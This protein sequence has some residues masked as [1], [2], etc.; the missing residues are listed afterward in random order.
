[1]ML[2]HRSRG[3]QAC[4]VGA[5]RQQALASAISVFLVRRSAACNDLVANNNPAV[6]CGGGRGVKGLRLRQVSITEPS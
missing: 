1:M 3:L 5:G 2:F 6:K 4:A